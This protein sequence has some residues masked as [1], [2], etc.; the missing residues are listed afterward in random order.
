MSEPGGDQE[1]VRRHVSGDEAA[2]AALVARHRR[3]AYGLCYR[4]LGN[5]H[6]AEDASQEAFLRAAR[7]LADFRGTATFKSW[8]TRI[9]INACINRQRSERRRSA[10]SLSAESSEREAGSGGVELTELQA[11]VQAAIG[12]LPEKQRAALVLRV[13][14]ELSFGE[15]GELLEVTPEAARAN[16]CLARKR[17]RELLSPLV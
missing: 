13:Y 3:Y 11:A 10:A 9:L 7:G 8:L 2:F 4:I 1:L 15:I 14:E 12:R 16:V 6:D 17:L 5:H